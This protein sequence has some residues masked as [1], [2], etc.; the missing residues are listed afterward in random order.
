MTTRF[1]GLAVVFEQDL[2]EDDAKAIVDAIKML[3]GV[4]DVAPVEARPSDDF[5]V[6]ERV[7]QEIGGKLLDIVYPHR[8]KG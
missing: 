4:L 3:R 1:K 2:R 8:K 7:R 6:T 5:F